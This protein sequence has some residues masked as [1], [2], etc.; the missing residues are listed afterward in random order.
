MIR[1]LS[2]FMANRL[3]FEKAD[4]K[5]DIEKVEQ[6]EIET[7]GLS[8]KQQD[9]NNYNEISTEKIDFAFKKS[10][11]YENLVSTT[12]SE[13]KDSITALKTDTT[14]SETDATEPEAGASEP[15][16]NTTT[17]TL[18][19]TLTQLGKNIDNSMFSRDY[20]EH[21]QKTFTDLEILNNIDKLKNDSN[22]EIAAIGSAIAG[23]FEQTGVGYPK[24]ANN[25]KDSLAYNIRIN[26]YQDIVLETI[27]AAIK[28]EELDPENKQLS[29]NYVGKQLGITVDDLLALDK[30]GDG[31][32]AEEIKAL[33]SD[34]SFINTLEFKIQR[35]KNKEENIKIIDNLDTATNSDGIITVEELE[36]QFGK[37]E[38][39]DLFKN[40]DGSVDRTLMI[41][42][43]GEMT[44]DGNY[45]INVAALTTHLYQMDADR[46]GKITQEE[47]EKY[48]KESVV[49][50]HVGYNVMMEEMERSN[51]KNGNFDNKFTLDDMEKFI[52]NNPTATTEQKEFFSVITNI[53]NQKLKEYIMKQIGGGSTTVT[54]EQFTKAADSDGDGIVT[55][56]E[57]QAYVNKMTSQY[58]STRQ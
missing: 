35:Q 52:K 18:K 39:A 40:A 9:D 57:L 58:Y 51:D 8:F 19:E 6:Q 17:S 56:E 49:Y 28:G 43:G 20:G 45:T 53:R 41:A 46:D 23:V 11:I 55:K 47:V 13:L 48:K 42:L 37:N 16:P 27:F 12:Q 29:V 3:S 2:S 25:N 31:S 50:K 5:K 4:L 7:L 30:N 24:Q 38:I 15:A 54:I 32:I 34:E 10:S 14:E 26:T 36:K 22:P 21:N 33:L 44:K 1:N